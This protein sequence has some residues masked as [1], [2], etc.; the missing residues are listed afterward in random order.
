MIRES[1]W[2][3]KAGTFHLASPALLHE[4]IPL[5]EERLQAYQVKILLDKL[6]QMQT[7]FTL[8]Y[9]GDEKKMEGSLRTLNDLKLSENNKLSLGESLYDW[10][11]NSG[12]MV[13]AN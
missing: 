2:Q 11:L 13:P 10:T 4:I 7:S 12:S 9:Q 6:S 5:V 1:V 8:F 3:K